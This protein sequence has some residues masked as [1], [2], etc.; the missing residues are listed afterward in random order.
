MRCY[1]V[2]KKQ[3][4]S[5]GKYKLIPIRNDDRFDI[6]KWRNEQIYHLR[7]K[8]LLTI[9]MQDN[10][11][12][13]T[14]SPLFNQEFPTQ[15]LFSF[16]FEEKCIG[17]GGLVHINWKDMN[18]EVSLVLNA[19]F[20]N[21]FFI[22]TW[23][24]YLS[25]LKTIAFKDLNL[26]KIFTYA[27]DIRPKLYKALENSGFTEE[28]R[29]KEHCNINGK[30]LDVVYHSC[31]NQ[32]H[33]VSLREATLLDSE[34][35]FEWTNDIAVRQSSFNSNSINLN[36]HLSWFDKKLKS[37][38][39]KIYIA[40]IKQNEPIGQIRIDAFEDYWLINYSI[41]KSFRGLGFGKHIV[42]LMI[43]LNPKKKFLAKVKSVNIASQKVFENLH[44][45]KIDN[46]KKI[47]TYKFLG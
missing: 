39:T 43:K 37:A 19:E 21:H 26:Y 44:F 11:F 17:Y 15:I 38:E 1:K 35:L 7:Q 8:S 25:L 6:M 27:F 42:K 13:N 41:D 3:I 40:T 34:L 9:K 23:T 30:F 10:Y 2:L 29:L 47:I 36:D 20:N 5:H 16:M 28:S 45:N 24:K 22:E 4:F 31:F 33:H 12:K 46:S 18:A 32:Y 14:I